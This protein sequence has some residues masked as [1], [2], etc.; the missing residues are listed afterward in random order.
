MLALGTTSLV[1][2][3]QLTGPIAPSKLGSNYA[4]WNSYLTWGYRPAALQPAVLPDEVLRVPELMYS[5]NDLLLDKVR[6]E[7]FTAKVS[8]FHPDFILNFSDYSVSEL[9]LP[10]PRLGIWSFVQEGGETVQ[11]RPVGLR[12]TLADEPT[13]KLFLIRH[14]D[15]AAVEILRQGVFRTKRASLSQAADELYAE[16]AHWPAD[17][18]R[19]LSAGGG[20]LKPYPGS[21]PP[22]RAV[23]PLANGAMLVLLARLAKYK[24]RQLYDTFFVA[25]QWN[26][27]VVNRPVQDFLQPA[28]LRGIAIDTPELPNRNVFYADCFARQEVG[29]AAVY[30]EL[31]DYRVRRGNISRLPYP[32][33]PG[34]VPVP[35]LNFPYHLSYPFLHGPY[36]IPEGWVT[37]SIRLYD[38]RKPVTDPA[39]GQV[40]LPVPGVDATL[41]E[42]GGRY[43]LFYTR[44]DRDAMLNL[45]IAYADDLHG[46]W[47]EHAQNPVK[48]DIRSARPAGPFF[49]AAGKLYRPTQDCV[50][51]Y[52]YALSIQEVRLLTP[53]EYREQ[54]AAYLPSLHPGYP[55]GMHTLA[56]LDATHTLIDFKRRRFIPMAT[57]MAG[58]GVVSKLL[59]GKQGRRRPPALAPPPA[60]AA[61]S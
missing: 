36:C 46:P 49:E 12:E 47:H 31:Y 28:Q 41:L 58:W 3:I 24:L 30:F 45:F 57:L 33:Q 59:Y 22:A 26:M 11:N 42:H 39:A 18:C 15:A 44:T 61:A 40:L 10:T 1:G 21:L 43:W 35:V 7:K 32:W 17:A 29:G 13:T 53:T 6:A 56:A 16:C 14:T 4:L 34:A 38:L 20:V 50:Q 9:P 25:D 48:T 54:E 8:A 23:R 37:Q 60:V 2:R 55:A 27:G 5:A 19:A 51:D 52:G